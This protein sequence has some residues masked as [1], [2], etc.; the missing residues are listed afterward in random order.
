M[1]SSKNASAWKKTSIGYFSVHDINS[2]P[3]ELGDEEN[4]KNASLCI[5][6]AHGQTVW[7][8]HL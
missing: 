3:C 5:D 4:V 1:T 8:I 2:Y 6:N 7:N